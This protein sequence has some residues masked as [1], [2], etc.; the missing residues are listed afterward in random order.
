MTQCGS[1][2][3]ALGDA[4]D[5][6]ELAG[7]RSRRV[8]VGDG[9]RSS[10]LS[11]NDDDPITGGSTS[12]TRLGGEDCKVRQT[13][14]KEEGNSEGAAI[15][16]KSRLSSGFRSEIGRDSMKKQHSR[17]PLQKFIVLGTILV[18]FSICRSVT[19][20]RDGKEE[21]SRIESV[22]QSVEQRTFNPWV[23]SSSL[24]ALISQNSGISV[25]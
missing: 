18:K 24:S 17:E 22:A 11:I 3:A 13:I 7:M 8:A 10:G 4:E 25:E 15:G 20:G 2:Q 6:G 21:V 23:E 9:A 14:T 1:D 19:R 5:A 12:P 16:H